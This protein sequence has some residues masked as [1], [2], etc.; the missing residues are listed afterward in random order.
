MAKD[1]RDAWV[2]LLGPRN[3]DF[4]SCVKFDFQVT[5]NVEEYGTLAIKFDL[6]RKVS[7]WHLKVFG[8]SKLLA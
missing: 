2:F 3:E 7:A 1:K 4:Q 6:A 5:N 8:D